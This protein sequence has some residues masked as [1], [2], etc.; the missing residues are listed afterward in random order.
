MK[1]QTRLRYDQALKSERRRAAPQQPYF[2]IFFYKEKNYLKKE[3]PS[4]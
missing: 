1:P 4:H 2:S 3:V